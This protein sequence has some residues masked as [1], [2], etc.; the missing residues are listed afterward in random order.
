MSL[1]PWDPGFVPPKPP[2]PEEIA[3]RDE[4]IRAKGRARRIEN[5]QLK[6][7]GKEPVFSKDNRKANSRASN[8]PETRRRKG[9]DPN[10]AN[11]RKIATKT[12]DAISARE[13]AKVE[14]FVDAYIQCHDAP[15]AAIMAGVSP[16][17]A[18][19]VGYEM[20]RWPAVIE[21]M[22]RIVEELEE[23]RLLTRKMVLMGLLKEANYHGHDSS[24]G[25]RVRA[26]MGLARIKKMDVQVTENNVT[27]RGG[28]MV[29]PMP[30]SANTIDGW[31]QFA[32]EGQ[33][34]LKEDVRK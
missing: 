23:E 21:R 12:S 17:T 26:W 32:E 2:T 5:E 15:R 6:A 7:E 31:A 13:K 28:I 33:R 29:V 9:A 3:A 8:D 19:Q 27:V 1:N 30:E 4:E 16:S 14:A 24:H 18:V 20:L 10:S 25:S 11:S 22:D 34:Q